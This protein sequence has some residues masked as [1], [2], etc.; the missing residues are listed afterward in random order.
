MASVAWVA[1]GHVFGAQ[2]ETAKVGAG[3]GA[4]SALTPER[5]PG[6][7]CGAG[8]AGG[9]RFSLCRAPEELSDSGWHLTPSHS[10]GSGANMDINTCRG[11]ISLYLRCSQLMHIVNGP[12]QCVCK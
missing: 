2:L 10:S 9:R 11:G 6:A 7:G 4:P 5:R 12:Q 8:W 1:R 3:A